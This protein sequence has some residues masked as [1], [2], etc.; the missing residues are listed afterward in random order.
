M[1]LSNQKR[2]IRY[3]S[4]WLFKIRRK[5]ER[6]YPD[7]LRFSLSS[8]CFTCVSRFGSRDIR[9][10]IVCSYLA[11]M[12]EN[13]PRKLVSANNEVFIYY[14]FSLIFLVLW[15]TCD[16]LFQGY[17]SSIAIWF[18]VFNLSKLSSSKNKLLDLMKIP[19]INDK[20]FVCL[21]PFYLL[22][23]GFIKIK[24]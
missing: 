15:I 23:V 11:W 3:I 12:R 5:A 6:I 17:F 4:R 10:P 13:Y 8:D 7:I 19:H 24:Y 14:A 21:P 9:L 20:L 18:I 1:V 22:G 2:D 16:V